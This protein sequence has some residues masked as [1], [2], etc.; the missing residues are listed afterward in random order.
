MLAPFLFA[1]LSA[2]QFAMAS[3]GVLDDPN[4][5]AC[6][7]GLGAPNSARAPSGV[8]ASPSPTLEVELPPAVPPAARSVLPRGVVDTDAKV[9]MQFD[10]S[11]LRC[12]IYAAKKADYEQAIQS[13]IDAASGGIEVQQD[14]LRRLGRIK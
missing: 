8:L 11:G 1:L 2:P 6:R 14:I 9:C 5:H 13:G 3:C 10:A 7:F 12:V 4:S